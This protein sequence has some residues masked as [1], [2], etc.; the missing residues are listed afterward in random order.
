MLLHGDFDG[1]GATTIN[2]GKLLDRQGINDGFVGIIGYATFLTFT[3]QADN[4]PIFVNQTFKIDDA[5]L[6][7]LYEPGTI[8]LLVLGLSVLS[9]SRRKKTP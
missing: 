9:F 2:I 7:T 3:Y 6:V 1:L 8:G 5:S 4:D